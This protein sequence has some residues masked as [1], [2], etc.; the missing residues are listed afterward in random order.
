VCVCVFVLRAC[1]I[2]GKVCFDFHICHSVSVFF[3]RRTLLRVQLVIFNLLR[4]KSS[5]AIEFK[6]FG[7]FNFSLT[8]LIVMCFFNLV[9]IISLTVLFVMYF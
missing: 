4:F 7:K 5:F 2:G 8:L 9:L 3:E 6:F 1:W